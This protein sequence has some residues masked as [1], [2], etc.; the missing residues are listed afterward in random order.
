MKI[1]LF[2]SNFSGG[3]I[4]RVML[5]LAKGFQEAGHEVHIVVVEAKGP[6]K[7]DVPQGVKII[8][9]QTGQA[10]RSIFKLVSYLNTEKPTVL[11]SAQT[12]FNVV[13]I[14]AKLFS[15][16]KGKLVLSEHITIGNMTHNWK[17]K[18]FPLIARLSYRLADLV[19]LV[20]EGAANHF[21]ER[22]H[23][24][25][26][27]I[28]TIYNPFDIEKIRIMAEETPHHPW[29]PS[30]DSPIFISAGRLT[31]QKDFPTLLKAFQIV[32]AQLPNAKLVILGDGEDRNE[33]E[34]LAQELEIQNSVDLP[35]F[36]KNPFAMIA[37]AD[38]F[39]LS[40]RW[41]GFGNVIVEALACGTPVISTNC[42]SGPAEIL[43]NGAYGTLV[44]VGDAQSLA[45]AMLREIA[46]PTPRNKLRDRANDFSIE[47][48]VPEYLEAFHSIGAGEA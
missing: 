3:G 27:L 17:E 28:R 44:P 45:Q 7:E 46:V 4:Q 8:N 30:S 19:L 47:K 13:A 18:L 34:K 24:P 33:L 39:I 41:E 37:R 10:S 16:W 11:L 22:T 20:S 42:P 23:L 29:F 1:G 15:T 31:R 36:V 26:S 32:K 14:L 43:G 35:G 12:H 38:A 21:I 25:A 40:S 48:I 9:L 2:F 5:T 6:L